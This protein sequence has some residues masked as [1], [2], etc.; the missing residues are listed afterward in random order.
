MKSWRSSSSPPSGP[1]QPQLPGLTTPPPARTRRLTTPREHSLE[2]ARARLVVVAVLFSAAW[3]LLGG[4]LAYLTL[5]GDTPA[6]ETQT[7]RAAEGPSERADIT[8]RNGTVLAT[9]LPTVSLCADSKDITDPDGAARQLLSVLPDLNPQ[10]LGDDLHNGKHCAMLKRHLTP[11]QY[12]EV[13]KLGIAG[14]EFRPDERRLYPA[15]SLTAHVVGYTDIDDN[16]LAGIEKSMDQRLADNPAPLPLSID[17][18]VQTIMRQNLSEAMN[19]YHA[20][21]GAGLVM[22][23]STGEILSMVSLPD[24]DPDHPG[25]ATDDQRFNRDT[26]GVYEM[27]STF[28]IFNTALALD[29]GTVH[30]TDTF[31]TAHPL[32]IGGHKIRDFEKENRNLNVAEIFTHSS[33]IGSARMAQR[34]GGTLQRAFFQRLGLAEKSSIE[35]P[36]VSAPLIP[37]ARDWS[38]ATTLTAA[39]G[40]G[41]AVNVVQLA[42]A[43][44]TIVNDG[45]TV[46]PTLLKVAGPVESDEP[47][48]VSPRT[49]AFIR[50]LMRLV[51]TRGTA[52]KADV[53]GYLVAGKTGTADKIGAN[54]H[55]LENARLSSFIGVFPIN[56]PRY[57]V[58]ALLDDPKG[59][60]KTFG[61]ATGGWV[62]A[63]I[64]HNVVAQIGPLLDMPP[65]PKDIEAAAQSAVLK[66]FGAELVDGKPVEEGSNYASVESDSVQ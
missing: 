8:D 42:G 9:A 19:D 52:K 24:F 33:N 46:K 5:R 37:S 10:R 21:G 30:I 48:A 39:F 6:P 22:D 18:R 53:D 35:L 47:P 23:I 14:L 63:P 49:S 7:A 17:L 64:V 45:H 2:V 38:E 62:S 54:H 25:T 26:L 55:Y 12:Y 61:F 59:N 3:L 20:I 41:V 27:G 4:R 36:E 34:F 40:H 58:F 50:G 13:N 60:A 66:P 16:G 15:G 57:L 32:E 1:R 44:A 56:A 11:H 43:V 51:V 31:D 28:K 29:S 65:M